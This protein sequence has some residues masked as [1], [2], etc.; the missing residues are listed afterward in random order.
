MKKYRV[1]LTGDERAALQELVGRV[2]RGKISARKVVRACILLLADAGASDTAIISATRVGLKTVEQLRRRFTEA[3]LGA[4]N[5]R[6]RTG[7]PPTRGRASR[8]TLPSAGRRRR[9]PGRA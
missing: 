3:R 6:P 9:R 7:R 4:L 2:C 8:K 5:E 1:E